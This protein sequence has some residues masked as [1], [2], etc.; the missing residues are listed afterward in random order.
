VKRQ[1]IPAIIRLRAHMRRGIRRRVLDQTQ[2]TILRM[3]ASKPYDKKS[4]HN[5]SNP[6]HKNSPRKEAVL[7]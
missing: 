2:M 1:Y 4:Q 3:R 7:F 6:V 5:I